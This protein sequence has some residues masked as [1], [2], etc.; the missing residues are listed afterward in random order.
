MGM[1][2]SAALLSRNNSLSLTK[3][4]VRIIA[5]LTGGNSKKTEHVL[6]MCLRIHSLASR[7][8]TVERH[9]AHYS[10]EGGTNATEKEEKREDENKPSTMRNSYALQLLGKHVRTH[11]LVFFQGSYLLPC[12]VVRRLI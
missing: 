3:L 1:G 2:G 9:P 10:G 6:A 5:N 8:S 7:S 12:G 11:N 4:K